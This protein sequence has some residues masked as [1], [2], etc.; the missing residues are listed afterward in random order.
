MVVINVVVGTGPVPLVP[1]PVPGGRD[2]LAVEPF[3]SLELES[4]LKLSVAVLVELESMF[5]GKVAVSVPV[6]FVIE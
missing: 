6:V 1:L 3:V 4:V 2:G 5:V